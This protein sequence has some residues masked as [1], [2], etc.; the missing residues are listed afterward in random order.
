[1]ERRSNKDAKKTTISLRVWTLGTTLVVSVLFSVAVGASWQRYHDRDVARYRWTT[2]MV[3]PGHKGEIRWTIGEETS[4]LT[5]KVR[6]A[7]GLVGHT[8]VPSQSRAGDRVK[9]LVDTKRNRVWQTGD[10]DVTPIALGAADAGMVAML[11]CLLAA[12]GV[13]AL[14]FVYNEMGRGD[15]RRSRLVEELFYG[16]P[17]RW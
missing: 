13:G 1:M 14:C 10:Y 17:A 16:R 7:D 8:A 6:T 12:V 4:V 2:A 3:D 15:T 5:A 9:V 11:L